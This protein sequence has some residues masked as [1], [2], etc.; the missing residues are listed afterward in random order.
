MYGRFRDELY[1]RENVDYWMWGRKHSFLRGI[2]ATQGKRAQVCHA[3]ACGTFDF[4]TVLTCSE[5]MKDARV[6]GDV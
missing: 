2:E 6:D 5:L 4:S 1:C 3:T